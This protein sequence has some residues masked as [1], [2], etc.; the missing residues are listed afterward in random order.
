MSL[1]N[2]LMAEGHAIDGASEP[3]MAQDGSIL[4]WTVL[5]SKGKMWMTA[6]PGQDAAA[7]TSNLTAQQIVDQRLPEVVAHR[8]A[9]VVVGPLFTNGGPNRPALRKVVEDIQAYGGLPVL[10]T[11]FPSGGG[12]TNTNP[13]RL[14]VSRENAWIKRY[15]ATRGVPVADAYSVLVDPATDGKF[16]ANL[17]N[18]GLHQN[19]TG[20][21]LVGEVVAQTLRPLLESTPGVPLAQSN[22]PGLLIN[23][24]PLNIAGSGAGVLPSGW[25]KS[26]GAGTVDSSE[27]A[28]Y[29]NWMTVTSTSSGINVSSTSPLPIPDGDR[30]LLAF[31]IK[32]DVDNGGVGKLTFRTP[33]GSVV[34]GVGSTQDIT[35]GVYAGEWTHHDSGGNGN[36]FLLQA[37]AV[38]TK[39]AVSQITLIDLTAGQVIPTG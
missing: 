6:P 38:G 27:P 15:A 5:L 32:V 11:E 37:T 3:A 18:D 16:K 10:L 34:N 9:I 19:L 36:Y 33:D 25:D 1:G 2:S 31:R 13:S 35:D 22:E 23:A 26:N 28:P 7:A 17:S 20:S 29:G 21:R 8:P 24:N 12:A 14:Y 4:A 30:V 39:V